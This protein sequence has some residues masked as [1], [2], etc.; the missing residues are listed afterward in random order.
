MTEVSEISTEAKINFYRLLVQQQK[1]LLEAEQHKIASL[2]NS[3][4]LLFHQLPSVIS[5]GYYL[6]EEDQL[7][8]GPFQGNVS[9]TRIPV[10]KG[11]CGTSVKEKRRL[12][13]PDVNQF[14]GH[15]VCNEA[16]ASELVIP[17]VKNDQVLGVL[18]IDSQIYDRFDD[19]DE[20]YLTEIVE[21][22]VDRIDF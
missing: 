2:A 7:I 5:A 21:L 4:A 16:A 12:N 18:D 19:L 14:A 3:S 17:L 8:L 1:S 20:Q 22:L 10:G 11:V 9:C 6:F 13:V 15:I